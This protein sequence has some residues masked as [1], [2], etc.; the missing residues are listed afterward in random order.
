MLLFQKEHED[1]LFLVPNLSPYNITINRQSLTK[2][3]V[4]VLFLW[5]NLKVINVCVK[6]S[7]FALQRAFSKL[8]RP[9][10][11][12]FQ[13]V[14]L[15][16][17]IILVLVQENAYIQSFCGGAVFHML[18][19]FVSGSSGPFSSP[20]W[21]HYVGLLCKTLYSNSASFHQGL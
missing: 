6:L 15:L 11:L 14:K 16:L 13:T 5:N 21:G 19:T 2:I 3:S 12:N 18:S 10:L 7:M 9:V 17:N 1:P 4:Q 8:A 20:G